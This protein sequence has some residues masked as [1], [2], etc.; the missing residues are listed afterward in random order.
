MDLTQR[1]TQG[2]HGAGIIFILI[3]R[4][5]ER[6]ENQDLSGRRPRGG[7]KAIQTLGGAEQMACG[8][9]VHQETLIGAAPSAR[10][11]SE[12]R[13]TNADSCVIPVIRHRQET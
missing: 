6:V 7:D 1:L 11:L 4:G 10:R 8:A 2:G 5:V 12:R 3:V 9:R 13:L